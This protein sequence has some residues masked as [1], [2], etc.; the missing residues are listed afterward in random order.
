MG[1]DLGHK[2][3]WNDSTFLSLRERQFSASCFFPG[4]YCLYTKYHEDCHSC[5]HAA[6]VVTGCAICLHLESEIFPIHR[7][8][9]SKTTGYSGS[10]LFKIRLFSLTMFPRVSLKA[11]FADAIRVVV[12]NTTKT[13]AKRHPY[14]Y[15][16]GIFFSSAA[17]LG[18]WSNSSISRCQMS[19]T[20]PHV[21]SW[22][23]ITPK[24]TRPEPGKLKLPFRETNVSMHA[25]WVDPAADS[26]TKPRKS[27]KP[28][29]LHSVEFLPLPDRGSR[30]TIREIHRTDQEA[31]QA[32]AT[33]LHILMIIAV[34]CPGCLYH[35]YISNYK[36]V[37]C[38][39]L[40]CRCV[41]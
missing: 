3:A 25:A 8:K 14:S 27:K 18:A 26:V 19:T 1:H 12:N 10:G 31:C 24:L 39:Y 5:A 7:Y 38:D 20:P 21:S 30:R 34:S 29:V 32:M 23:T 22:S 15:A 13:V 36:M 41:D 16:S 11:M 6:N 37:L 28:R 9:Q 2:A 35:C 4:V 33:T 40:A 17:C